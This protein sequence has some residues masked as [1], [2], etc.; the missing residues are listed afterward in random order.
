MNNNYYNASGFRV[1]FAGST[2]TAL[3]NFRNTGNEKYNAVAKGYN[4]NPLL[5]S[6]G[7]AGN[8]N[9]GNPN[10]ITQYIPLTGSAMINTGFNL[11]TLGLNV[12]TKDFRKGSIPFGG[13]YDIGACEWR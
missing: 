5:T 4:V 12:G 9:T 10:V 3:A 8:V 13:G 1:R 6:P 11:T 2:Y 7:T